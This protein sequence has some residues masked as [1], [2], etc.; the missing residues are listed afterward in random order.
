M[1]RLADYFVVV[2]YDHGKEREYPS[3]LFSYEM[4]TC[5]HLVLCVQIRF[6]AAAAFR[7]LGRSFTRRMTL[8]LT[9]RNIQTVSVPLSN[10]SKYP[11]FSEIHTCQ[12]QS[13]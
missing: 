5:Q 8:S 11:G 13:I 12:P 2:G 10:P 6:A 1:S 3:I 7:G 4:C 9:V